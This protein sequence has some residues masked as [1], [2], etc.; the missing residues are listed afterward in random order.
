[1]RGRA[2]TNPSRALSGGRRSPMVSRR[3]PRARRSSPRLTFPL[4]LVKAIF[5]QVSAL[6]EQKRQERQIT[7]ER[8]PAL[9]MAGD[10]MLPSDFFRRNVVLSFQEDAIGIRLGRRYG[11][12]GLLGIQLHRRRGKGIASLR[13]RAHARVP[14]QVRRA[15]VPTSDFLQT[16][17]RVNGL[18][19]PRHPG[20]SQ[21][22]EIGGFEQRAGLRHAPITR[23]PRLSGEPANDPRMCRAGD[24]H[25]ERW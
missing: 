4:S 19:P 24:G 8:L 2:D 7:Q 5:R 20:L 12:H 18:T 10:G 14:R 11:G 6:C 1:V 22:G 21:A 23:G 13:R 16:G 17:Y 9:A 3:S 15:R 25:A